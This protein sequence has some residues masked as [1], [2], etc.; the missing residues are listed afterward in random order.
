MATFKATV[1]GVR[2]DGARPEFFEKTLGLIYESAASVL[3]PRLTI[4]YISNI[5]I[6]PKVL[7]LIFK[8]L[9]LKGIYPFFMG[10]RV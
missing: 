5:L 3:V 8:T 4:F 6:K 7:P 9:S 1:H 2:T 10:V